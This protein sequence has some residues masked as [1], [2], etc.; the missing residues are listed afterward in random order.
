LQPPNANLWA[1]IAGVT[2]FSPR[3]AAV[4]AG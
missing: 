2:N 4:T 3:G 1:V